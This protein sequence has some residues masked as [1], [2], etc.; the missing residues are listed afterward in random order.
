MTGPSMRSYDPLAPLQPGVTLLEASAGTGKTY[1]ITTLFLRLVAEVGLPAESILV[2][3]FTN[4]AT[5]ELRGRVR[6][7]LQ[8]AVRT[9]DALL[10]GQTVGPCDDALLALAGRHAGG[11]PLDEVTLRVRLGRLRLALG[12]FDTVP[13]STIHGFCG[14][15]L[16]ENAFES[17]V[18][19]DVEL[20]EGPGPVLEEIVD[21]ALSCLYREVEPE[22]LQALRV[23]A[24]LTREG[25]LSLAGAAVRYRDARLEP[26]PEVALGWRDKLRAWLDVVQSARLSWEAY[27]AELCA[28][29]DAEAGKDPKDPGRRLSGTSYRAGYNSTRAAQ[30]GA[31]LRSG[32]A[33]LPSFQKGHPKPAPWFRHFSNSGVA[34]GRPARCTAPPLQHR[35]LDAWQRLVDLADDLSF[36]DGPRREVVDH[37]LAELPVRLA[38][39]R[40]R[41]YDDL[42][43]AVRDRVVAPAGGEGLVRALRSRYRAALLDEFQDTDD[44]QWDVF[45]TVFGADPEAFLVLIGDPKQAIYGFRGADV[46]TYGRAAETTAAERRFSLA[47]NQRSDARLVLAV[48]ALF[49]GRE[50]VFDLP[51]IR[52]DAVR[53]AERN[54]GRR[55][56]APGLPA[57]FVLRWFDATD[58]GAAPEGVVVSKAAVARRLAARLLATDVCDLL[59]P[60]AGVRLAGSGSGDWRPL[61]ARDVAVLVRTNAQALLV[62]Q[63][64]SDRGQRTIVARSGSVFAS[65]TAL[66][67]QRWLEAITVPD[68]E[69][70]TRVLAATSWLDWPAAELAASLQPAGE[71]APAWEALRRDVREWAALAEHSGV[72]TALQRAIQELGVP[73]RL[74][75]LPD[76]ERRLTDL[77]HL[78][79]LLH[80]EELRER[81]GAEGLLRWLRA[82]RQSR[83]GT[84]E[85]AELRLESDADAVRVLT[86]HASKGLEF[87]VVF[88]PFLWDV[89]L[90]RSGEAVRWHDPTAKR[91]CLDLRLDHGGPPRAAHQEAALREERQEEL[92]LL[93][94]GVTRARHAAL[95]YWGPAYSWARSAL[96]SVLHGGVPGELGADRHVRAKDRIATSIKEGAGLTAIHAD[97]DAL[98]QSS[99]DADGPTLALLRCSSA[100]APAASARAAALPEPDLLLRDFTR[101]GLD[102][103]WRRTSYSALAGRLGEVA[104]AES[105]APTPDDLEG[106]DY[107]AA[108]MP[109]DEA[110]VA[111][112]QGSSTGGLLDL[113]GGLRTGKYVHKLLELVDFTSCR[114]KAPPRRDL[115]ALAIDLGRRMGFPDQRWPRVV[116]EA[117]PSVLE[118]PLGPALGDACLADLP[119]NAR[120]DEWSFDLALAGGERWRAGA[121]AVT[122]RDFAEV[123]QRRAP[124]DVLRREYLTSL[125]SARWQPLCGF[126]TGSIDLLAQLAGPAAEE[127]RASR[128]YVVDYKTNRL[129]GGDYRHAALRAA[130]EAHHYPLQY[131][132]YLVALHRYL[133]WRLGDAYDYDRHVGGAVYLF[134]RGLSGATARPEADGRVP[135]VFHDRPPREV[136]EGLSDLFDQ[137]AGGGT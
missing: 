56:L 42:L 131:H 62:R 99:R 52:Y 60:A 135:G 105:P 118:T 34:D 80:V 98:V 38:A 119:A 3:T 63:A 19:T 9:L 128:W 120:L 125:S 46:H 58:L 22:V 48:N 7:R 24:G 15:T 68:R 84:A 66:A 124:D 61:V 26:G 20:L 87:P 127:G 36:L 92:R 40:A 117:L 126:L 51:F 16:D 133:R 6:E 121:A 104:P 115:P 134:L 27:S 109:V 37:V 88:L 78:A 29:F 65:E 47:E 71:P 77:R 72:G 101:P 110:P 57:P 90:H 107:D 17:G 32:G 4:A 30:V 13:I 50:H 122:A 1:Q 10:A 85:T 25:L 43:R 83:E 102:L 53:P 41:T 89:G 12:A 106:R 95:V 59:S 8:Q 67:L 129:A 123:F 35:L 86:L 93:Y 2:V 45:A 18:E 54:R 113:P 96:A 31:W 114:E 81:R 100:V 69:G 44:V 76:G 14:R 21:D 28:L 49:G 91:L 130:M 82:E 70:P 97:L 94:V 55:F 75:G 39:R 136:V 103:Q 108:P 23:G 112:T 73:V 132:L 11:T 74:A 5:A 64:L 116:A 33:P 79:E 137:P 111:P